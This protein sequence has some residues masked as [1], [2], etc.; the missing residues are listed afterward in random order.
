MN[1]EIKL[2]KRED[3]ATAYKLMLEAFEEYR[4]LEIPSSA[5]NESETSIENS[6][7]NG[8]EKILLCF[9]NGTPV[10]TLRFS[11][12]LQSLYFSRVSVPP[13]ARG[14]GLAKAMLLWLE[15]YAIKDGKTKIECRVR[16]SLP[17]NIRLYESIGYKLHKEETVTNPNGFQVKTVIMEKLIK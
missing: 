8:A 12:K 10:G 7:M 5:L 13:Y 15:N 11:T 16:M 4:Y 1:V 6:F 2:G 17:K 9:L 14:K 3:I